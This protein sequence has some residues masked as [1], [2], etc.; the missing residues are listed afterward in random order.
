MK[1]VF[2]LKQLRHYLYGE[3]F[4][5]HCDHRSL[6]YLFTQKDINLR[7]RRWLELIKD[8]DFSFTYVPVAV[9]ALSRKSADLDR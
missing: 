3:T 4:E 9:Y 8:Y 2:A 7:Q 6:Q 5:I 1:V